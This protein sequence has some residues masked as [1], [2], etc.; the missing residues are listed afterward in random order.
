MIL[1]RYLLNISVVYSLWF[2]VVKHHDPSILHMVLKKGKLSAS[3][4]STDQEN[5]KI[6]LNV[7]LSRIFF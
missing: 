5:L 1:V 7:T 6:N 4:F 3:I 2:I